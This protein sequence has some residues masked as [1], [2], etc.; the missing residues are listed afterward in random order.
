MTWLLMQGLNGAK[1]SRQ[2]RFT[3]LSWPRSVQGWEDVQ[4]RV[5]SSRERHL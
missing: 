5:L 4:R 1:L 3:P 2:R